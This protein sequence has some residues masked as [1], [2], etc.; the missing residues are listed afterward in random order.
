MAEVAPKEFVDFG[1]LLDEGIRRGQQRQGGR[2]VRRT[3]AGMAKLKPTGAVE[4]EQGQTLDE[5]N[6]P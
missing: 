2:N 1:G 5:L 6:D 4:G 3:A